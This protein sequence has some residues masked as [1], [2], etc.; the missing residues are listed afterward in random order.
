LGKTFCY[1]LAE[2]GANLSLIDVSFSKE[3]IDTLKSINRSTIE[4]YP[5]D[6][7]DISKLKAFAFEA[8]KKL[9][10]VDVLFSNVATKGKDIQRFFD[11]YEDFSSDVW[12]EIMSVNLDSMFYLTQAVGSKMALRGKGS[13]ILTGSIYG[14]L[15]PDQRIYEGSSYNNH[16]ISTPAVYSAAKAGVVGLAKYLAA[17]W[18]AKN[19]RVNA[20]IPGGIESGQNTIFNK[21]YSNR[22]PL[23]RMGK[24]EDLV[25][26]LIYLAS[27]ASSYV[28]G[29]TLVVDG[30]LSCW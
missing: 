19:I 30:G 2:F 8:E 21:L 7:T 23:Q 18:G 27:D 17:Y 12:R 1:A 20:L 11:N 28:S 3:L 6:V 4:Y 5:I 25:G 13:I 15:A 9:G 14:I 24:K 10:P 29:Q 16:S 26:A 22:V